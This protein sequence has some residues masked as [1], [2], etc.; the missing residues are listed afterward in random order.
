MEP[1]V[2]GMEI[3][4]I[5][6]RLSYNEDETVLRITELQPYIDL[7]LEVDPNSLDNI[8]WKVKNEKIKVHTIPNQFQE[9]E[10]PVEVLGEVAGMVYFKEGN[11]LR[12][13]GRITVNIIDEDGSIVKE[14]LT[15][16]DGYFTYLGLKPGNYTA[17]I[18]P[19]Q[20]QKLGYKASNAIDF[21]IQVD[22]YGDIVDTLEF[23]I[24]EK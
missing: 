7:I 19:V 16:G 20:M 2:S 1:A 24:E 3:K 23:T 22:E 13:Q 4:N 10:V 17:E 5:S 18:D 9:I 6:G 21:E 15:E 14:I 11:S 8:A 12:G